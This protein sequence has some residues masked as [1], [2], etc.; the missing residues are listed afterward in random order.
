MARKTGFGS[1]LSFWQLAGRRKRH[2]TGHAV[3]LCQIAR[4]WKAL[5][6]GSGCFMQ[7]E[8]CVRTTRCGAAM[9]I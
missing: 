2:V 6:K 9:A 7:G 1:V 5:N 3:M 8:V 4:M